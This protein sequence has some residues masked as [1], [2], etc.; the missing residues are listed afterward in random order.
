[1]N[2]AIASLTV[3]GLLALPAFTF[4]IMDRMTYNKRNESLCP[5][6]WN[7]CTQTCNCLNC[8]TLIENK[9]LCTHPEQSDYNLCPLN[10]K[11]PCNQCTYYM[12]ESDIPK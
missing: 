5:V 7:E 10:S 1:M 3:I 6:T 12:K 11:D 8:P 2:I 9:Y 4:I